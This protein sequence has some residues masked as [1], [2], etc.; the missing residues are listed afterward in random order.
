MTERLADR[1]R[2]GTAARWCAV[3]LLVLGLGFGGFAVA[4]DATP[5]DAPPPDAPATP[6]ADTPPATPPAPQAAA[7]QRPSSFADLAER[8]LPA[9]VNIA[10]RQTAR[11]PNTRPEIPQFPPGS[12]F[13]EFFRDFFDHRNDTPQRRPLSLGSGFIVDP[14]GYIVTNNHVIDGA[15]EIT[16]VLHDNTNLPAELIGRDERTD[17]AILRV[18]PSEP[19]TAVGWGDSDT[20][21][22]GDWVL[23]I[24]NPFGLG[25]TVTAGIISARARNIQAGPYDD[26]LQTDAA[27]NRGNSGGPLFNLAGEVVGVNTAIYSPTGGSVGIGFAVPSSLARSVADQIIRFGHTRRG[28]M[29]VRIQSVTPEI[30]ESI[31]LDSPRGALVASV[32]PG[33]PAEAAGI[34]AGDVIVE[35]NGREIPEMRR[36][37]RVVA[38]TAVDSEASVVLW[39]QGQTRTVQVR[40]GE[41]EVAE[42]EGLLETTPPDQP[43]TP[44]GGK[45]EGAER[46][47]SALGLSLA[48]VDDEMRRQYNLGSS[49]EGVVITEVTPGSPAAEKGLRAGEVILEVSQE[50]VSSPND[51]TERIRQARQAGRRSVLLL[52]QREQGEQHF[53]VLGIGQG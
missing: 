53:V 17:I 46:Q 48:P 33:G 9:V 38:E 30:A 25:G 6:P 13:E 18:H 15:D 31:G 5:P 50:R 29:G 52:V 20:L 27:I 34:Q 42:R 45:P 8:L 24:G 39:R 37:P 49:V 16:V 4:Q 12:P 21:R 26:F 35:F 28:W 41:L 14:Q 7:P 11:G 32:T 36:L 51:V 1:Q 47:L 3:G 43:Q 2:I 44:G 10:T 19:L 40:L 22:V 23:A